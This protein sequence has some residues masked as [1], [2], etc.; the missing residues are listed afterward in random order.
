MESRI[1]VLFLTGL[2]FALTG[3][4]SLPF[5][6][7]DEPGDAVAEVPEQVIEPEVERR[8]VE[9]PKIDTENFEIGAFAGLMSVEDFGVNP[10]YGVRLAYHITEG[11]FVEGAYGRTDTEETSF[12]RLSGAAEILTDDEREFTYYNASIGYNV[13][14]GEAFVG[15]NLAF[16]QALYLIAGI[17]STEF[18]GDDRFTVNFGFGYRLLLNDVIALHADVRDHLF[19]IDILGEEKTAHNIEGHIGFTIFF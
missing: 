16:S 19:D 8:D 3:C 5:I 4:G 2:A 13:L 10:V 9:P 11:L 17:G 14:P 7:G 12:E 1:R 18:A 15:R 6:G